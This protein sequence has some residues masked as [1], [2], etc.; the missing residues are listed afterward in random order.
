MRDQG[1]FALGHIPDGFTGFGHHL[2]A[3]KNEL[4]RFCHDTVSSRKNRRTERTG[5]LAACPKPQ[6]EASRMT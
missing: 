6:I 4:N 2:T 5:L 3:I 1:A